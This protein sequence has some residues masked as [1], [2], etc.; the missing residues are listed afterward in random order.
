[1][2]KREDWM[3]IQQKVK[4]GVYLK[5]IAAELDVHPRTVRRA[6][7]RGGAPSGRRPR[8][9]QRKLDPYKPLVD[10]W[11]ADG[12]WNAV[13][14]LRE[15]QAQG[16]AGGVSILRDYIRPKRALRAARATVRFET[17]PGEQLQHDW[18]EVR[19]IIGGREQKVC[20]SVNTLGYSRRFHF[21][22]APCQDAEHTL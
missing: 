18:G 17:A 12:V 5:D 1:M 19:T 8:A 4:Q 21:W 13:V 7:Q 10:R 9:R 6:L 20:F 14:I 22:A 15:I 3:M 16:Y 2:L 11:L